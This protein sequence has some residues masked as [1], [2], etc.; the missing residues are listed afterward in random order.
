LFTTIQDR[1]RWGHQAS[2]VPVAGPMDRDSH[3][4]ANAA[5]GNPRDAATLE[6]TLAGPELRFDH[7][8]VV[9]VAGADISASVDGTALPGHSACVVRPGSTLHFGERKRG[10]RAYVAFDGGIDVPRVLGSRATHALSGLGG[11]DGRALT[12]GDRFPLGVQGPVEADLSASARL[13]RTRRSAPGEVG[14]VRPG[15]PEGP[16][17]RPSVRLRV[18]PGPQDDRFPSAAMEQLRRSRFRVSPQSNRM[19]YRLEGERL[20][21][22]MAPEMISGAAFTGGIQVPPSGEPI[23]L[24]ADR[25]TTGGYPQIATVITADLPQ[26]GQLAPGDWVEFEVC[27]RS[28]AM[29]ALA[30]R[31]RSLH[32]GR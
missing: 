14:Q 1:G 29:T 15:G 9:A 31:Q 11:I 28:E 5:V 13:R 3:E 4:A 32:G 8:A 7:G 25:Q 22:A 16:P 20:P 21:A 12:A 6:V 26:A 17:L 19:G 2:G 27:T 18:L 24:M 30:A 10:A 23:L